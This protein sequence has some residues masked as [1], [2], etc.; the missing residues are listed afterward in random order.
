MK[1]LP[2]GVQGV[3]MK[4][5]EVCAVAM[6]TIFISHADDPVTCVV[7]L[8]GFAMELYRS[9]LSLPRREEGEWSGPYNW[10]VPVHY[11]KT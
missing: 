4:S 3:C 8:E 5:S 7:D 2:L 9:V 10:W 11:L 1:Y 6:C